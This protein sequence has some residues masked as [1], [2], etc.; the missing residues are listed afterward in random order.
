MYLHLS[1]IY[2][3]YFRSIALI[4]YRTEQLHKIVRQELMS[5]L[6]SNNGANWT[7]Y[8][9]GVGTNEKYLSKYKKDF[10]W[11]EVKQLIL[12]ARRYDTNFVLFQPGNESNRFV[13]FPAGFTLVCITA[14]VPIKIFFSMMENLI[15][16]RKQVGSGSKKATSML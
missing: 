10:Q 5:Y 1:I 7:K 3:I 14:F 13:N 12:A 4:V 6:E 8:F 16:Q 9:G 11:G 15:W 2:I